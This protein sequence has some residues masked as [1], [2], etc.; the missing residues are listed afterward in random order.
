MVSGLANQIRAAENVIEINWWPWQTAAAAA[1]AVARAAK[2]SEVA[3]RDDS[4]PDVSP[5][6]GPFSLQR[7]SRSVSVLHTLVS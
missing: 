5:S 1:A 4:K 3:K 6:C 2:S 7:L